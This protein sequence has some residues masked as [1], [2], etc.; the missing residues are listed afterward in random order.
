MTEGGLNVDVW[1]GGGGGAIGNDLLEKRDELNDVVKNGG[2]ISGGDVVDGLLDEW[3]GAG[4]VSDAL[5]G[6]VVEVEV[7][8]AA[9]TVGDGLLDEGDELGKIGEDLAEI[10]GFEVVDELWDEGNELGDVIKALGD[11]VSL[12]FWEGGGG[13]ISND[14]LEG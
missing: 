14:L 13:A 11:V 12:E 7:F 6:D 4:D 5:W 2:D 8:L 3:E 9:D 1:E 10:A